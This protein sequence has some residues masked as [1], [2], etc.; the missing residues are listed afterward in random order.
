MFASHFVAQ[1]TLL[2]DALLPQ[3]PWK[4]RSKRS[5]LSRKKRLECVHFGLFFWQGQPDFFR[6][7]RRKKSLYSLSFSVF[8]PKKDRKT[9]FKKWFSIFVVL[10][11]R[12][13]NDFFFVSINQ[14]NHPILL[15][16]F[17]LLE[18]ICNN[19]L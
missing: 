5:V 7:L 3:S 17:F 8:F 1:T 15:F 2:G 11:I 10:P 16:E 14:V 6:R 4:I 18:E 13:N 19:C 12:P 9:T